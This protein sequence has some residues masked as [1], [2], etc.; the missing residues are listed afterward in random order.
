MLGLKLLLR[1]QSQHSVRRDRLSDKK[2]RYTRRLDHVG[3]AGLLKVGSGLFDPVRVDL[4]R[5][6]LALARGSPG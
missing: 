5:D 4:D 2:I 3:E 6:Q 1:N